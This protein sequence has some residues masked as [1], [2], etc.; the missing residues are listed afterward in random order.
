MTLP[1]AAADAAVT[2]AGAVVYRLRT[3]RT[4]PH[5]LF[6]ITNMY[7]TRCEYMLYVLCT[8]VL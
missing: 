6:R 4:H 1:V 7:T 2:A 8:N 5:T 3:H